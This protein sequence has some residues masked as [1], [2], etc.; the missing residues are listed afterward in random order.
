MNQVTVKEMPHDWLEL[1]PSI[2]KTYAEQLLPIQEESVYMSYL[3]HYVVQGDQ[4]IYVYQTMP[5][6]AK[7]RDMNNMTQ[8]PTIQCYQCNG[9]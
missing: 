1:D 6:N 8:R 9:P 4:Y 3:N 2:T 7:A 5:I